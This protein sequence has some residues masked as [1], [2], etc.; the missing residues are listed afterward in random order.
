MTRR[1]CIELITLEWIDRNLYINGYW[2]MG[3][4]EMHKFNRIAEV[5]TPSFSEDPFETVDVSHNLYRSCL[6]YTSPSPRD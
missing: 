3:N 6:L 2:I 1:R 4:V 5:I